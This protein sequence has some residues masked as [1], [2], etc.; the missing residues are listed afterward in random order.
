MWKQSFGE[1]TGHLCIAH[2]LGGLHTKRKLTGI[3]ICHPDSG[4]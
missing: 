3:E 2:L 1:I 4:Q